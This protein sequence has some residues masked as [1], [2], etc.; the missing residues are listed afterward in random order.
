MVV[1][2]WRYVLCLYV[3]TSLYILIGIVNAAGIGSVLYFSRARLG[4]NE[5]WKLR[6]SWLIVI[7]SSSMWQACNSRPLLIEKVMPLVRFPLWLSRGESHLSRMNFQVFVC[8]KTVVLDIRKIRSVRD[9]D[10]CSFS[11]WW[12]RMENAGMVEKCSMN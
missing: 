2:T 9:R 1:A 6:R 11:C 12:K 8:S 7:F 4:P 10:I 3:R 5:S